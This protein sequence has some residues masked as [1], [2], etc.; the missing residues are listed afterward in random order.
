MHQVTSFIPYWFQRCSTV[1]VLQ[2][3]S[4]RS[5]VTVFIIEECNLTLVVRQNP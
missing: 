1:G 2:I 3:L 4:Q 5:Q